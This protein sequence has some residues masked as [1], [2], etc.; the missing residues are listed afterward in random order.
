MSLSPHSFLLLKKKATTII[1]AE[2][3]KGT[4]PDGNN[5]K[6]HGSCGRTGKRKANEIR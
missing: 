3:M 6:Q 1:N 2:M 5:D 4:A